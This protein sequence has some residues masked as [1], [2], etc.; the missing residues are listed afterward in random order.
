MPFKCYQKIKSYV[1]DGGGGV[2]VHD[3]SKGMIPSQDNLGL[4]PW[5][6]GRIYMYNLYDTPEHSP[7]WK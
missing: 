7:T 3:R 4:E 2:D 1:Y 5:D 6:S